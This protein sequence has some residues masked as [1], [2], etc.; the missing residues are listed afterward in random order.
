L[1][2]DAT[3]IEL[4]QTTGVFVTKDLIL[5]PGKYQFRVV[6]DNVEKDLGLVIQ[7]AK[8]KNEDVMKT[9]VPNTFTSAYIKMGKHITQV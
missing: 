5:K 8:D 7:K 2:K 9:A 4:T 6:N 1:E 3:V